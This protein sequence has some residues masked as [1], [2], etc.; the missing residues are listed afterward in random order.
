MSKGHFI[1]RTQYFIDTSRMDYFDGIGII[2]IESKSHKR[3][4]SIRKKAVVSFVLLSIGSRFRE[5]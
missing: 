4:D 1:L 2:S 5:K 3:N